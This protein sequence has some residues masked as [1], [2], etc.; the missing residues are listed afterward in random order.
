MKYIQFH[1][2]KIY[3]LF[4]FSTVMYTFRDYLKKHTVINELHPSYKLFLMHLGE[5][6]SGF[7]S[8]IFC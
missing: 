1:F 7:M 6:L 2:N 5:S 3:Y 4:I 8:K